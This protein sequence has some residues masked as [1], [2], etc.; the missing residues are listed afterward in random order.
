M[1]ERVDVIVLT[2]NDGELLH[3]A[4]ESAAGQ[5][6]V[7]PVVLVV[8]NASEPPAEVS[9]SGV[10]LCLLYTSPSPRD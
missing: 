7:D 4:V 6:G 9:V 8:D 1:T 2:W 10:G 5:R 3:D